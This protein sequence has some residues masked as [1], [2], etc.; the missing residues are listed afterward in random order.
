[1]LSELPE[2][3]Y[4]SYSSGSESFTS[5]GSKLKYENIEFPFHME[6]K[7]IGYYKLNS[8]TKNCEVVFDLNLAGKWEVVIEF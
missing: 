3:L 2:G 5:S 6:L 4:Q 7:F 1:M 8:N